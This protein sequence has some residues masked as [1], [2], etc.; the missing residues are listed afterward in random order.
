M[1]TKTKRDD[2]IRYANEGKTTQARK[3]ENFRTLEDKKKKLEK[4]LKKVLTKGSESDILFELSKKRTA[5]NI[6]N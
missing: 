5:T 1:L 2:K 4:S 6:E 3:K